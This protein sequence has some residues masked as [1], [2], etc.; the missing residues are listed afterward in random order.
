MSYAAV[1]Q[2][3]RDWADANVKK[4]FLERADGESRFCYLSSAQG[5]CYQISIDAPE[6]ELV[7]VHVWA[8]ETLDDMEAH[9]EWLVPIARL[10]ATLDTAKKPLLSA[11]G[12]GRLSGLNESRRKA[13]D[14]TASALA[15]QTHRLKRTI[16]PFAV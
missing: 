10:R 8:V 3:I 12:L 16:S 11:F 6:N 4:L 7:R 13:D 2:I 5:E 15:L 14:A 1:D 9:L